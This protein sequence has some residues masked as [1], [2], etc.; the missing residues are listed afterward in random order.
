MKKKLITLKEAKTWKRKKFLLK[1]I[2]DFEDKV[3]DFIHEEYEMNTCDKCNKIHDTECLIWI[4]SEDFEPLEEDNF[5]EEKYKKALKK[6]HS[7][8]CEECY[9]K[10][11][12]GGKK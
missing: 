6:N 4:D 1:N 3:W 10:E 7:A 9:K 2:E 8:L 12:C 5:N 11:C